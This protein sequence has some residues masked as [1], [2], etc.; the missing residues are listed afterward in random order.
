[1]SYRKLKADYLFDGYNMLP[2]DSVLVCRQDGIIEDIVNEEQVN[3]DLEKFSGMIVP[4]L[5]NCHCHLEL[6][7]LKGIIPEKQGL[8]N[9]VLSVMRQRFQ[10]DHLKEEEILASQTN[11]LNS[12]IV[13]LGDICNTAD[14]G[15]AKRTKLLL[16]YNFIEIFGWVPD[17]ATTR[18]E[19]GKK[20]AAAFIEMGFDE[21]HL[22]LNP[23]A[24]YSVSDQLWQLLKQN[25]KGK[26]ITIHNQESASENEYFTSGTGDLTR[27]YSQMK[28][29]TSHFKVPVNRSLPYILPRLQGAGQI[30]LVHNT[31]TDETDLTEIRGLNK[32]VFLCLCPNANLYIEDSL[33]D[34]PLFMKH[35]S[36]IVLGTDSLA[37]NHQLSILEEM[38]T[39]KKA[40][41]YISTSE[42]LVW[43]TSNGAKALAFEDNLGDF[44]RGKKPGVVLLE[45][46]TGGEITRQSTSRRLL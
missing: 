38:K 9:F 37:S 11:M 18:H 24:P 26:T 29:D 17:Q 13:A 44:T 1:M 33:P 25:F 16:Y 31:Y 30:L 12:G 4:G 7:H 42:M 28:M 23:H 10:T 15:A 35:N 32:R 39:I 43:A 8:T 5:I 36:L 6:S 27:M 40:F 19:A 21:N 14:S 2:S 3:G 41:P 46:I 45:N 22:S 34:I 20:L